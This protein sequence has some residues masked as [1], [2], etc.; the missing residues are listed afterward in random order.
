MIRTTLTLDD[1][2]TATEE[3]KDGQYLKK[4]KINNVIFILSPEEG[5]NFLHH[6]AQNLV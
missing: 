2:V 6:A 1:S 3:A 5:I 4:Y